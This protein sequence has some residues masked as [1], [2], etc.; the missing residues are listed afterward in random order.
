MTMT[1]GAGHTTAEVFCGQAVAGTGYCTN[2]SLRA[3]N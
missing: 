3:M 1:E 2:V